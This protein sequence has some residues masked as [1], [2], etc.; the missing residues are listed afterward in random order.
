MTTNPFA[1]LVNLA[2][3][4]QVLFATDDFF[5]PAESLL[6][7]T[8]PVWDADKF[9]PFGKWM[10]GWETRRKR[11]EGHDWGIV[12]L[13]LSG[14]IEGVHIDTA[15]FTGNQVPRI[16]L[17]AACLEE[18]L[19]LVRRSEIGTCATDQELKAAGAVGSEKWDTILSM[20]PLKPG[21]PETR[22]HYFPINKAC[23]G[24]RYTHLRINYFPDGGVARLRVYGTVSKDWS[25][26]S[27]VQQFDL[28][29]L[30]NG[31][32]P[33]SFTNSHYGTPQNMLM[34]RESAGMYDGWETAR[35]PNRPP[36]FKKDAEGL[37][38]IPGSEHV[39]I[40]LGHIAIPEKV[41]IDTSH[42]KGNFPES[43]LVESC[44]LTQGQ[45]LNDAKWH[46][47]VK[48]VKCQPNL[49]HEFGVVGGGSGITHVRLTVFPDGGIA[50][51]RVFGTLGETK[52]S[53]K[54]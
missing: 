38:V 13:G 1:H 40:K 28:V 43:V 39:V 20:T 15:F 6:H 29:A 8:E 35:N 16:S 12:K 9:T 26:V 24:K 42:F 14:E 51:F 21:Y 30:E 7:T 34:K 22:H 33:V 25:T 36:I 48:R 5:Q 45:R 44:V 46:V 47:L 17:Q 10:D 32:I 23:L 3:D 19:P 31:G 37:L 50:R 2:A 11:T 4:G 54:L 18:D 49:K 52:V 41:V 53:S 27:P